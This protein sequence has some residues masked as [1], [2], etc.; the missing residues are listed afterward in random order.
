M[1]LGDEFQLRLGAFPPAFAEDAAGADGDG[2]LDDVKAL[3]QGIFFRIEQG[4]DAVP[5]LIVEQV[6]R[7]RRRRQCRHGHADE[8]LP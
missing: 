7:Q 1:A 4:D 2:G 6:P 3:A 5:L 8:D